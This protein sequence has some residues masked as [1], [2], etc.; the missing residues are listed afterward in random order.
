M[1]ENDLIL[2]TKNAGLEGTGIIASDREDELG[3]ILSAGEIAQAKSMLNDVSVV[4]EG[5]IAGE[6][7]TAGMHDVTEGGV[8]GAVWEMCRLASMGAEIYEEKIFVHPVTRK[9]AKHFGIDPM[10]LISSGCMLIVANS[11]QA[12]SIIAECKKE[13]SEIGRASCR[14]RV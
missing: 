4:K 2:L 11:G 14:E 6:I 9:I 3:G 8:Y 13:D 1:R 12:D 5:V 7:G 10:R